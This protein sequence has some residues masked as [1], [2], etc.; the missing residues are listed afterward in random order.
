M[1]GG[2]HDRGE[3]KSIQTPLK[4]T[5]IRLTDNTSSMS[6]NNWSPFA[7]ASYD[8]FNVSALENGAKPKMTGSLERN[9]EL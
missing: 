3:R 1:Q 5:K 4:V 6:L 9:M 2:D 7:I 8:G